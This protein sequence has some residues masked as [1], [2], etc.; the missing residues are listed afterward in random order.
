MQKRKQIIDHIKTSIGVN[1]KDDD[2]IDAALFNFQSYPS[3][4]LIKRIL[5]Y[6]TKHQSKEVLLIQKRL[7]KSPIKFN[8]ILKQKDLGLMTIRKLLQYV[9]IKQFLP[10]REWIDLSKPILGELFKDYTP[11]GQK[12]AMGRF[13]W[14]WVNSKATFVTA[15]GIEVRLRCKSLSLYGFTTI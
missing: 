14:Q 13:L 7:A 9:P 10:V 12:I 11:H 4:E 2:V 5:M 6:Y 8:D 1:M 3:G 15:D